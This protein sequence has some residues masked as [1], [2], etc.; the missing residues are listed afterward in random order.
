MQRGE[1]TR[2]APIGKPV[3]DP[4]PSM[5][6]LASYLQ[7]QLDDERGWIAEELHDDLGGLLVA[8]KMD[9]SHALRQLAKTSVDVRA[10]LVQV[11]ESLDEAIAVERRMVERLQPGLLIHVGLFSALR[12]Y[13]DDLGKRCGVSIQVALPLDELSLPVPAKLGLYRILQD[14]LDRAGSSCATQI[15]VAAHVKANCLQMVLT[16]CAMPPASW[17]ADCDFRVMAMLQRATDIGAELSRGVINDVFR[18]S[19]R[20]PLAG[21]APP[22]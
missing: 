8:A 17:G 4:S 16:H 9:V 21:A 10:R 13:V 15:S 12:S 6:G 22:R 11:Q 18:L 20:V 5:P 2:A 7:R 1:F 3:A 14:E 19:I